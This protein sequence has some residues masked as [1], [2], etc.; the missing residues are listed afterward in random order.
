MSPVVKIGWTVTPSASGTRNGRAC[1]SNPAAAP[2]T[3]PPPVASIA[4]TVTTTAPNTIERERRTSSPWLPVS[5]GHAMSSARTWSNAGPAEGA[6]DGERQRNEGRPVGADDA[7]GDL[8]VHDVARRGRRSA[9]ARLPGRLDQAD[10]PV[11]RDR[12][13]ARDA[14]G[15]RRLDAAR[16]GGRE[17]DRGRRD[18]GGLGPRSRQPRRR[19]VRPAEGLPRSV[20]DVPAAAA[21][22]AR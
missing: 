7:A 15:A 1:V 5:A 6:R 9:R 21:R 22:G 8:G 3:P 18:G 19:V 2:A 10:V 11:A 12:G 17:Q 4:T 14:E 20:R 16:L 13:S